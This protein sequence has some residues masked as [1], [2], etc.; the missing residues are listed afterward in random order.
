[1]LK[2][3]LGNLKI[4]KDTLIINMGSA[5]RCPSKSLG[6]CSVDCYAMKA[7]R[8]YP[9][10]L[11]YRDVQE[12]YWVN[13]DAFQIAED[14]TKFI[15]RKKVKFVRFNEAGDLHTM[16]CLDKLIQIAKILPELKFYTYTHRSD[17]ITDNTFKR[18]PKNLAINTSNFQRQGLNSFNIVEGVKLSRKIGY[19]DVKNEIKSLGY[20]PCIGDCSKCN[21]CK[22]THGKKIG[23]PLH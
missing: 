22:I 5:T 21:L 7:E 8:Q 16:E 13:T 15:G 4:G 23:V 18:L 20:F 1:M 10:V 3:K 14:I 17:L 11:P 6:L 9:A 19:L 2:A 12:Q